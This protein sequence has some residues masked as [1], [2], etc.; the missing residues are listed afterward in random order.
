MANRTL[1][2]AVLLLVGTLCIAVAVIAASWL[3][4]TNVH[5][6]TAV[7][8][9]TVQAA[10]QGKTIAEWPHAPQIVSPLVIWSAFGLGGWLTVA[11]FVIGLRSLPGRPESPA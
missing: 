6:N 7:T 3:D 10:L 2:G 8:Q 1:L 11:G 5:E 4:T 9:A